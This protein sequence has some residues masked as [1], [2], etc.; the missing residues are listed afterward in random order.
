MKPLILD[1]PYPQ[2]TATPDRRSG[3]IISFAYASSDGEL[4]ATLQY[5][6]HS[7]I[8]KPTDKAASDTLESIAVAEM[9]HLR[10]LGDAMLSLGVTPLYTTTPHGSYYNTCSV[11]RSINPQ[12]MLMDNLKG[13]L[14]AI[15]EYQK[16]LYV[17]TNEQVAALIERIIL[18]E[19]LHVE[20]LKEL[21][22]SYS[23]AD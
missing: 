14:Q 15:A 5:V 23:Q 6:F 11:A 13:E 16:M 22:Q 1:L 18:D 19:K 3:Q 21:L 20:K 12:K 2:I 17:L 10:L 7:M 8:F 9:I 4:N